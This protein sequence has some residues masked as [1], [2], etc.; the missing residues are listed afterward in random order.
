MA[1]FNGSALFAP[2]VTF[3]AYLERKRRVA[4]RPPPEID[5]Y[6]FV[7][8]KGAR[9]RGVL[10][11]KA[12]VVLVINSLLFVFKLALLCLFG[13]VIAQG[14]QVRSGPAVTAASFL[15]FFYALSLIGVGLG[16]YG[17]W[18]RSIKWAT[19][20]L[21]YLSIT[22]CIELALEGTVYVLFVI[23]FPGVR[24]HCPL[25]HVA[26]HAAPPSRKTCCSETPFSWFL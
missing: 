20:Y 5:G 21:V 23:E 11:M 6:E 2:R 7:L 17:I 26:A 12:W 8:I 3:R 14:V 1:A 19:A 4:T 9:R 24:P 15:E 16:N 25:I 18:L 10:D 13:I 22:M